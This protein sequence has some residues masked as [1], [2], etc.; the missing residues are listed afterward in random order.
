VQIPVRDAQ[1][2]DLLFYGS[3]HVEL[4]TRDTHGS[5]GALQ[6]GT[7]LGWHRWDPSGWWRPTMAF[8]LR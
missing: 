8:R 6:T 3:G 7:R 5:F 1:R 4:K 2:G